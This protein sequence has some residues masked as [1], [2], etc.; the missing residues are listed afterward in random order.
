M[1]CGIR[2]LSL[3]SANIL[4]GGQMS[5][6]RSG[7]LLIVRMGNY[8]CKRMNH[9]LANGIT[10][11]EGNENAIIIIIIITLLFSMKELLNLH[12]ERRDQV[13]IIVMQHLNGILF[14]KFGSANKQ[15]TNQ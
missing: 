14:H 8:P 6:K 9:E 12:Q 4:L 1:N 10:V 5:G 11:W 7:Q 13:K 2:I 15:H 3:R